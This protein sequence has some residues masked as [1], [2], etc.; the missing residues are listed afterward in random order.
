MHRCSFT[1][2]IA[3]RYKEYRNSAQKPFS[4]IL[5]ECVRSQT[6][7]YDRKPHYRQFV[8]VA[9]CCRCLLKAKLQTAVKEL[10]LPGTA[11][12]P[13]SCSVPALSQF[14]SSYRRRARTPF[15]AHYDDRKQALN[16]GL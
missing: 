1:F 16:A 11:F 10:K 6:S 4:V 5:R 9:R 2:A 7:I 8:A 3:E 13:V 12:S 14:I 15:S